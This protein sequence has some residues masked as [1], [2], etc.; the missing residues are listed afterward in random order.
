MEGIPAEL[1]FVLIF[2]VFS[3]LEAV[4]RKKG[5]QRKGGPGQSPG[6]RSR[7]QDRGPAIPRAEEAG[8]STQASS[9]NGEKSPQSSEGLV[10]EDVWEE[11]LGL[12]RGTKPESPNAGSR[13]EPDARRDKA[14]RGLPSSRPE[15]LEEIP[16]FE[17]RSLESLEP[18]SEPD[19]DLPDPA[20]H[21]RRGR[22]VEIPPVPGSKV[23][24]LP[25]VAATEIGTGPGV[26]ARP[27]RKP[28]GGKV[29]R[30]IFGDG[31]LKELRKAVI[32][33]EV[34]GKPVGMKD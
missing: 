3:I 8:A 26:A 19:R 34:L 30:E 21:R 31:S 25:S 6:P 18:R 10:P 9:R 5:A 29:R 22:Q 15:T 11:I 4:G 1:I 23:K 12:A 28:R 33:K 32:L 27:K 7:Q 20:G 16:P 14:G 24:G 13:S 2:I 17:A